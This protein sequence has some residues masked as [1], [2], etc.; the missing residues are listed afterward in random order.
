MA[1]RVAVIGSFK[2]FYDDVLAAIEAF[3]KAGWSVASPAGSAVIEPGIDFVRFETD[4]EADTDPLVQT[5]TLVN[6]L[7]ADLTYVVAPRGYVG[8][9][10]CYEIGRVIQA[11]KPLYI[12]EA[13]ADLPIQLEGDF[14]VSAADLI[15]RVGSGAHI[16]WP[17]EEGDDPL[18]RLER[19][20]VDGA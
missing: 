9:T 17:F 12:S 4:A 10:T 2:Q 16:K 6:I 3:R 8:R 13:V 5:R 1:V 20:L 7:G 11:R 15:A 19:Q 18:P 14:V